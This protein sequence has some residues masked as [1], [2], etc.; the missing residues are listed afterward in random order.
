MRRMTLTVKILS[1][2]MPHGVFLG[3]GTE[4]RSK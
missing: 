2:G 4:F 1:L 3:E